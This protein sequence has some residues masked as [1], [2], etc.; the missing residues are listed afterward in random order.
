MR[1]AKAATAGCSSV[2][3]GTAVASASNFTGGDTKPRSLVEI[4]AALAM[5]V[6]LANECCNALIQP[7]RMS[8]RQGLP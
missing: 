7:G 1:R 8:H 4:R 6:F 2:F 3:G 5:S